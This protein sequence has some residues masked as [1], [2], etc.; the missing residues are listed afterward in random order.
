MKQLIHQ[1]RRVFDTT[2]GPEHPD[3]ARVLWGY[4]DLMKK[5]GREGKAL[6]LEERFNQIKAKLLEIIELATDL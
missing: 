2:L 6:E 3:T 4:A 1:D 5:M